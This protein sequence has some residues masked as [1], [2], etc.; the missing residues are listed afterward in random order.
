MQEIKSNSQ[1][2]VLFSVKMKWKGSCNAGGLQCKLI[3][4]DFHLPSELL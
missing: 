1:N 2:S 3:S 4:H